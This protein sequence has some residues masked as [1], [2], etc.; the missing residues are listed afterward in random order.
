MT[1]FARALC[2]SDSIDFSYFKI[3]K[4]LSKDVV[5]LVVVFFDLVAGYCF[6]IALIFL[7]MF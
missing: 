1:Y 6:F 7:K 5:S 4:I 2:K 3:P